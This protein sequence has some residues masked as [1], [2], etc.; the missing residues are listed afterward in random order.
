MF[1][2]LL[3]SVREYKRPAILTLILMVGEA[4]IETALPYITATYLINRIQEK[5][6]ELSLENATTGMTAPF[7]KGAAKYFAEKGI[8]VDAQ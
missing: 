3:R 1:F 2:R 4:V 7:H 5:G 8:T 6:A